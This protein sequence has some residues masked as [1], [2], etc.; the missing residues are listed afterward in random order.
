MTKKPT[1]KELE[2]RVHELERADLDRKRAEKELQKAAVKWQAAFDAMSNSVSIVDFDGHMLQYNLA[3]LKMFNF[4]D[5]EIKGKQCWQ[6]IHGLSEPIENCP[7][8]RM[9]KSNQPESM[10]FQN[11]GRWLKVSV[12]PI[13]DDTGQIKDAV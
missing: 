11:K 7:I 13:F 10:T 5:Q 3:T 6:I 1:Y 9:K 2:K 12:Y 8:I 4:S